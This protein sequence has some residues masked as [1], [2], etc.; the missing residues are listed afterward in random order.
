MQE[1]FKEI[2]K[3]LY[4]IVQQEG[5]AGRAY[6]R[7][8]DVLKCQLL[9]QCPMKLETYTTTITDPNKGNID[10]VMITV[11][12]ESNTIDPSAPSN[13][14]IDIKINEV[15]NMN[16]SDVNLLRIQNESQK[17]VDYYPQYNTDL[18]EIDFY[19]AVS[20]V[21]KPIGHNVKVD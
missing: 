4:E 13:D 1:D 10:Q 17:N 5:V 21:V 14:K 6:L 15:Q 11:T 20:Y 12:S 9:R 8:V 3:H 2:D 18:N 16:L 7:S 19:P